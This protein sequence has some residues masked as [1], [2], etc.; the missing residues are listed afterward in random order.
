MHLSL[1]DV[2]RV[3]HTVKRK[4][5]TCVDLRLYAKAV[6]CEP[7]GL[8]RVSRPSREKK[9]SAIAGVVR[10]YTR[11]EMNRKDAKVARKETKRKHGIAAAGRQKT[12]GTL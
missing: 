4:P 5:S 7:D 11:N 12:L 2:M 9:S 8:L 10:E 6:L 3:V 1:F